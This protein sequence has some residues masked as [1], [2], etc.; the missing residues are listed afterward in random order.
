MTTTAE[1]AQKIIDSLE[2]KMPGYI[3]LGYCNSPSAFLKTWPLGGKGRKLAL[4]AAQ[5]EKTA[6]K[7]A[8]RGL[9][10]ARHALIAL[11]KLARK[12]KSTGGQMIAQF[13]RFVMML[14]MWAA[15]AVANVI[16]VP[17]QRRPKGG[18]G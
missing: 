10:I 13:M 1:R 18:P 4:L 6:A 15:R 12:V 14:G 7:G 16:D 3:W 8:A 17:I 2:N 9:V 5:K 11:E